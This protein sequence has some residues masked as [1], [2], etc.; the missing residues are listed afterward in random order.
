MLLAS[1]KMKIHRQNL[2]VPLSK[3]CLQKHYDIRWGEKERYMGHEI[4][5]LSEL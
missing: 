1:R 5:F 3:F 4:F 2:F